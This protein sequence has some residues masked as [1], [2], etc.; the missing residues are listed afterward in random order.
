M[1]PNKSN[2]K[3]PWVYMFIT[4]HN[5]IEY[6]ADNWIF[7][8]KLCTLL[9]FCLHILAVLFVMLPKLN[10]AN[11]LI[12]FIFVLFRFQAVVHLFVFW[13]TFD[14]W[15]WKNIELFLYKCD[16]TSGTI[17]LVHIVDDISTVYNSFFL[18]ILN[19]F[20]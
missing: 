6:I 5:K 14:S 1:L 15:A 10:C 7:D 19:Y 11:Y 12:W 16:V 3:I 8:M 18:Q 13:V 9:L 20:R 2:N 17:S 4:N